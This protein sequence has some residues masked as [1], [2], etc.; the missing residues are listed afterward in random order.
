MGTLK[1]PQLKQYIF[2]KLGHPVIRV[3]IDDTQLDDCID[4]ALKTFIENH[5][6]AVEIG[7]IAVNVVAGQGEYTL[8]NSVEGVLECLNT[9]SLW[10]EDEPLLLLRPNT[11]SEPCDYYD[12]TSV[13]VY[14]QRMELF[15][16]V[17][18]THILFEFNDVTKKLTFPDAPNKA[19]T[20]ILKIIQAAVDT[21]ETALVL[22]SLWLKKYSVAL[23]RIQ[24]GVNLGKYEGAQ[25]PGGVTIN[26]AGII[27]KGEADKE[28]LLTELEEKYT[29]PPDPVFA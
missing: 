1:I 12:V 4:E 16:D 5:Y 7:Y 24:W 3:E 19:Q 29:E 28:T 20:R 23:S 22:D 26:F 13:E 18:K 14:R 25:L 17:F 8:A 11:M 2:R 6:D 9:E 10:V 27:E 15:N 21:S